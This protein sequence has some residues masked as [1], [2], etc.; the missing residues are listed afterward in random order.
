MYFS[1]KIHN[2]SVRCEKSE[3]GEQLKNKFCQIKGQRGEN[4]N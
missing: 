1:Y 3:I 2:S 4:E